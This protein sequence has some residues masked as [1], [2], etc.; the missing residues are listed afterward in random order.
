MHDVKRLLPLGSTSQSYA[1][2]NEAFVNNG[3]T[4]SEADHLAAPLAVPA[5]NRLKDTGKSRTASQAL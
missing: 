4:E 2:D 3:H 1:Q 5:F